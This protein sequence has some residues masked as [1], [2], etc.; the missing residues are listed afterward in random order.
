MSKQTSALLE[1]VCGKPL[2]VKKVTEHDA[3]EALN[4]QLAKFH[5]ETFELLSTEVNALSDSSS[6]Q[7]Y[8][9]STISSTFSMTINRF[10]SPC[11]L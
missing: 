9:I 10:T 7:K 2:F 5:R 1:F 8:S 6:L 4:A 11:F 3:Q